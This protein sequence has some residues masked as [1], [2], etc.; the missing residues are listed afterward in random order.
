MPPVPLTV[1]E[2]I[3]RCP[4]ERDSATESMLVL[5]RA[6][7]YAERASI[8]SD[9]IRHSSER[10]RNPVNQGEKLLFD[11]LQNVFSSLVRILP[12]RLSQATVQPSESLIKEIQGIGERLDADIKQCPK[13]VGPVQTT[14][15]PRPVTV[16]YDSACI[17]AAE[18]LAA[19]N[20]RHEVQSYLSIVNANWKKSVVPA[21]QN[22]ETFEKY[23]ENL[24]SSTNDPKRIL[25]LR[26]WRLESWALLEET[27]QAIGSVSQLAAQFSK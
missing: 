1:D 19:F 12:R 4:I 25:Q 22:L 2:A 8:T 20:R 26:N 6:N 11:S 3:Q 13:V 7:A 9:S 16:S 24:H 14:M 18:Q 15:P 5:L 17:S 27:L 23:T 10:K 21:L